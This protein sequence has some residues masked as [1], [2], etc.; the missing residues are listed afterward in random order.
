MTVF[1]QLEKWINGES[2]HTKY[3]CVPDLSCCL[4]TLAPLYERERFMQAF[5]E[6][7]NMVM[8]LMMD[9]FITRASIKYPKNDIHV[10]TKLTTQPE[11]MS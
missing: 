5:E 11:V 4:D 3:G 8:T 6:H 10:L 2:V 7:D 1:E 9:M